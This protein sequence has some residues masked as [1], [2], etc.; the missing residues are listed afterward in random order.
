MIS[1]PR[2]MRDY[3]PEETMFINGLIAKAEAV[4]KRFGFYPIITPAIENNSVLTAKT[5][6]EE[7]SKEI[8]QIEGE[9]AGLRYD[10]TV[11]MSRYV[12]LNK[13]IVLPFKRYQIGPIWRR[14]E[15]QFMRS[16]EFIQ[17]DI[18]IV[19]SSEISSDAEVVAASAIAL[20]ELGVENYTIHVNSRVLIESI[21]SMFKVPAGKNTY[22]MRVLDKLYKLGSEEI[23]S[24]LVGL[25]LDKNAADSLIEFVSAREADEKAKSLSAFSPKAKQE[26][27]KLYKFTDLVKDYAIRGSINIDFSL[28]RGLDYYTGPIWEFV[29]EKDGKRLPTVA[30]GGRYDNLIGTLRG[31]A[32]L[33][34]TGSSIGITRVFEMLYEKTEVKT[35]AGVFV[36]YV[37]DEDFEY[38]LQLANRFRASGINTDFNVL[39]RSLSKQLSYASSLGI[40]YVAIIGAAERNANKLKLRNMSNGEESV[41]NFEESLESMGKKS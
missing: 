34:A 40:P 30:G 7:S 18:D 16:R 10:F 25:G 33:P 14:D 36:A 38:A 21:L 39:Q 13:N 26:L 8:F 22:A 12:A 19:G 31:G 9:E 35:H 28:T 6:G 37:S 11:P 41:L 20:D 24:Q 4:F 3:A 5:Y 2:G 27:D 29:A 15:P 32:P 1:L 23:S 17:A